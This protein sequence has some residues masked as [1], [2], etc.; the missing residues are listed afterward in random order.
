MQ[1]G[2]YC[3]GILIKYKKIKIKSNKYFTISCLIIVYNILP[4]VAR[5][6][7]HPSYFLLT[8]TNYT[9]TFSTHSTNYQP[10]ICPIISHK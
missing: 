7:Y 6:L 10:T 4:A 5:V 1:V 8:Q 9:K 2:H 3:A